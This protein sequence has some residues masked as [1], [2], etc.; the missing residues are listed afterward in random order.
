MRK[1]SQQGFVDLCRDTFCTYGSKTHTSTITTSSDR[2]TKWLDVQFVLLLNRIH[3]A[4]EEHTPLWVRPLSPGT[5]TY[6]LLA[7]RIILCCHQN[8]KHTGYN[9]GQ[10]GN[11]WTSRWKRFGIYFGSSQH[12]LGLQVGYTFCHCSNHVCRKSFWSLPAP[13]NLLIWCVVVSSLQ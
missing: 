10:F 4:C 9:S 1:T 13:I 7:H 2:E 5:S 12:Q 6:V 3:C 8:R 11:N